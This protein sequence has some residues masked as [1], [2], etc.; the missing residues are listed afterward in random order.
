MK[1]LYSTQSVVEFDGQHF[2]SNPVKAT[3]P[4]YLPL[5][6]EIT[7]LCHGKNVVT[8]QSDMIEDGAVRFVFI[9]KTNNL[10]TLLIEHNRIKQV[11]EKE[12]KNTDVC[13][14][15]MNGHGRM[16]LHYAQKYGKPIMSV[17]GGCPWDALWN[18]DWRGKLL[19]P[20]EWWR[21]KVAQ[22]QIPYTIYVTKYFL[23]GRYPNGGHWVACSNVN[24]KTGEDSVLEN[25]L[26][27][28]KEKYINHDVLQIGT[29]AALDVPYKGQKYVIRALA[30][31][32]DKGVKFEYHLIGRG[33]PKFLQK[34]IERYHLSE[35]VIIYGALPH[36]KVLSFLDNI[37]IYIQPSKQEG[38]P[39]GLIE[40]MSRGCLCIGSN[41][42]GIPELLEE[43]Y[44][45]PKGN[46]SRLTRILEKINYDSLKE[47]GLRNFEVAKEYD[48]DL[49]NKK[50]NEFILEFKKSFE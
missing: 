10:K 44:L 11:I 42:A 37:D 17:V 2:Y 38:L 18:Y 35:Q 47:Q 41:I 20:W 19:A 25:R 9:P 26:H 28:I 22:R 30:S 33:D 43:K 39:R 48:R 4:R 5:G 3:Y 45:F 29:S 23:Q 1:V 12:V 21:T 31:L 34:E 14:V 27:R 7:V 8:P 36:K 50:R 15:H 46:V 24:I 6:D 13:V 32:R 16:V 40:A 49:L